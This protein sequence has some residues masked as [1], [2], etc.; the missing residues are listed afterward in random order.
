M[1]EG[2]EIELIAS[3]RKADVTEAASILK[4]EKIPCNKHV[5]KGAVSSS[6]G[7]GRTGKP[8][9]FLTVKVEDVVSAWEALESEYAQADLPEDHYLL[10]SDDDEIRQMLEHPREW[11]P[12]DTG[13]AKII[14]QERGIDI[15]GFNDALLTEATESGDVGL[16]RRSVLGWVG[17]SVM[18]VYF[19][20]RVFR[21]SR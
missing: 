19:L 15:S 6:R 4:R 20:Q 18:V 10:S 3:S 17:I 13:H 1:S 9:Y 21:K 12:F 8:N 16:S 14:A 2:T 5:P 11:A 7:F